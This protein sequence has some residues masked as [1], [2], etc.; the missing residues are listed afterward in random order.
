MTRGRG[1]VK[2]LKKILISVKQ[3]LF[4]QITVC[5]LLNVLFYLGLTPE[6]HLHHE[7]SKYFM[8]Y[9]IMIVVTDYI[10]NQSRISEKIRT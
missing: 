2:G 5:S 4:S 1:L 6:I 9:E 7:N 8:F 10:N 3:S